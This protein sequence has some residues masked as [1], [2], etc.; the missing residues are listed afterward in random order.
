MQSMFRP[1]L[2]I[3]N[4]VYELR[5]DLVTHLWF[6]KSG[7]GEILPPRFMDREQALRF[8]RERVRFYGNEDAV[9]I[10]DKNENN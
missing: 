4:D 6:W 2:R 8:A 5:Q 7:I 1:V 9:L 10:G 3:Y